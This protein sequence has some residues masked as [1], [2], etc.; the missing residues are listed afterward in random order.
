[1][2]P[3]TAHPET[4]PES[5]ER[6]LVAAP[7]NSPAHLLAYYSEAGQDYEAW[8]RGFNMHFGYFR[9]GLNPFRREPM[10]AEMNQ[11]V[12]ERLALPAGPA[13]VADLGCGLGATAKHAVRT[14]PEWRVE[15]IT[16]V[17]WQVEQARRRAESEL[18]AEQAARLA[19]RQADYRALPDSD[20]RFDGAYALESSCHAGGAD[21][22]DFLG[23]AARVLRPGGRLV[24]VD[25]FLLKPRL[26]GWYQRLVDQVC[27]CWAVDRFAHLPAFVA[28]LE[29]RG[30]KEIR[31]EDWS[32]RIAPSVAHAPGVTLRFVLRRWLRERGGF[33]RET[34]RHLLACILSPL[35]GLARR[36]FGY[37][38]VSATRGR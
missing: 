38:C 4:A 11:Q 33:G 10:L 8:S 9:P 26:P 34:R 14:R 30:F 21:K 12:L 37:V 15:A 7:A 32:W 2:S 23:E 3:P 36:W 22:A 29:R 20:G 27:H 6:P 13:R 24:V 18:T 16:L 19:F 17:P 5:L 1:M 31:V 35:V 28:E 25:G